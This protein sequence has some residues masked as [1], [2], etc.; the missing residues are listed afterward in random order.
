MEGCQI[1]RNYIILDFLKNIFFLLETWKERLECRHVIYCSSWAEGSPTLDHTIASVF[2]WQCMNLKVRFPDV[3]IFLS[4]C[5]LKIVIYLSFWANFQNTRLRFW[6]FRAKITSSETDTWPHLQL[7]KLLN[8][9]LIPQAV[10]LIYFTC[11]IFLQCKEW[12]FSPNNMN[13]TGTYN[14]LF[15][16]LYSLHFRENLHF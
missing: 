13:M 10:K 3:L 15:E 11:T 4:K 9:I 5:Y 1:Y 2:V 8:K 7:D 14:K 6:Q 16:G 12:I